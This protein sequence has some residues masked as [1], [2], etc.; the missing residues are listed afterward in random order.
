[1]QSYYKKIK[2]KFC[3]C[4]KPAIKWKMGWVCADCARIEKLMYN[5][6]GKPSSGFDFAVG[7]PYN[8]DSKYFQVFQLN[9]Q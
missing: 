2:G 5:G 6:H 1:M 7:K 9:A 3:S 8:P 4:G